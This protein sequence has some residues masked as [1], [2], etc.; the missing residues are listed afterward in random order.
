MITIV[1][2]QS[3]AYKNANVQ[4][5]DYGETA[6]TEFTKYREGLIVHR[7]F[8]HNEKMLPPLKIIPE[9]YMVVSLFFTF[10]FFSTFFPLICISFLP[11]LVLKLWL[12]VYKSIRCYRR[13]RDFP[14]SAIRLPAMMMSFISYLMPAYFS[15]LLLLKTDYFKSIMS[16]SKIVKT[17]IVWAQVTETQRTLLIY[18]AVEHF[19][20]F[21][22]FV[23]LSLIPDQSN[24]AQRI[25]IQEQVNKRQHFERLNAAGKPRIEASPT[26]GAVTAPP[27]PQ[28][29]SMFPPIGK[30]GNK[31]ASFLASATSEFISD[32]K[33]KAGLK[34]ELGS[35]ISVERL[36]KQKK[37]S[38]RQSFMINPEEIID[39]NRLGLNN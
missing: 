24:S 4:F 38:E 31:K 32:H 33:Y 29:S 39:V 28:V 35:T 3:R 2:H 8:E 5:S 36:L 18:L 12:F 14:R 10:V 13:P 30:H 6:E 25:L 23:A 27:K 21:L 7:Q 16:V 34:G 15:V 1:N 11:F 22:T 19:F 9:F 37:A 17:N 26:G 20:L